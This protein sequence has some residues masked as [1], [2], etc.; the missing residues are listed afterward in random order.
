[1]FGVCKGG[2]QNL[3]KTLGGWG[4]SVDRGLG[5]KLKACGYKPGIHP[6]WMKHTKHIGKKRRAMKEMT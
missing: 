3:E 4:N 1:M 5:A 6:N 2:N